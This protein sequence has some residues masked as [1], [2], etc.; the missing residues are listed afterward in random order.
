MPSSC[1]RHELRF[2]HPQLVA[3]GLPLQGGH[4][5]QQLPKERHLAAVH[6]LLEVPHYVGRG[7]LP[8]LALQKCHDLGRQLLGCHHLRAA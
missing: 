5:L 6:T 4:L 2:Q 1:I 3:A 8:V 7:R